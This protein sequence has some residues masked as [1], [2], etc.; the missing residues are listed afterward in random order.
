ML[1]WCFS[2][3]AVQL[4]FSTCWTFCDVLLSVLACISVKTICLLSPQA[5][6]FFQALFEVVKNCQTYETFHF[7]TF[8]LLHFPISA[9]HVIRLICCVAL[10]PPPC[11]T[12]KRNIAEYS[13]EFDLQLNN[14]PLLNLNLDVIFF[15]GS[16]VRK[17][18]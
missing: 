2:F 3:S 5:S 15:N 11:W 18:S 12:D 7:R 4:S 6:L 13:S 1:L 16:E 8:F 17:F 10:I 14:T 9:C